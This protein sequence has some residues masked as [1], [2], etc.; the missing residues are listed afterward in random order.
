MPTRSGQEI[1]S[2][3]VRMRGK[4][5]NFAK[6]AIL[7]TAQQIC[8]IDDVLPCPMNRDKRSRARFGARTTAVLLAFYKLS[9]VNICSGA[10]NYLTAHP[11]RADYIV[12]K[13]SKNPL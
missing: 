3:K 4:L 9:F 5:Q 13:S 2:R 10:S 8:S 1:T 11:V 6:A 12:T 7:T